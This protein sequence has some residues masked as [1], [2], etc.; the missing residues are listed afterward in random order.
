MLVAEKEHLMVEKPP[1]NFGNHG[2]VERLAQIDPRELGAE[3][4]GAGA[5][6]GFRPPLWQL[7]RP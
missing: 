4:S 3:S 6:S 7:E 5:A 1:A 2:V